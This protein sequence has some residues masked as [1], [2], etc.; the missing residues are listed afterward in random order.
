[1]LVPPGHLAGAAPATASGV[2]GVVSPPPG[3]AEGAPPA[4]GAA[5][6]V[7]APAAG[8]LSAVQPG[9]LSPLRSPRVP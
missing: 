7:P 2:P 6:A 1:M 3:P 8:T 5:V 4:G 9:R